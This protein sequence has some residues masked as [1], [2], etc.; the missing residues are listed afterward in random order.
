MSWLAARKNKQGKVVSWLYRYKDAL[1]K[2]YQKSTKEKD[3][4]AAI[5]I[6]KYWDAYLRVNGCL[7]KTE[8]ENN[9][10]IGDFEIKAYTMKHHIFTLKTHTMHMWLSVTILLSGVKN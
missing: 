5:R 3:K 10:P 8:E 2:E 4:K 1:G 9:E 7:P 6:Q